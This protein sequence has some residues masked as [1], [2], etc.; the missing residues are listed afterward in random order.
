MI[1]LTQILLSSSFS[2]YLGCRARLQ[3][4][5]QISSVSMVYGS[6]ISQVSVL[7][8]CNKKPSESQFL[9]T[10]NI[11]SQVHGFVF[12]RFM[13][14]SFSVIQ[15]VLAEFGWDRLYFRLCVRLTLALCVFILRLWKDCCLSGVCSCDKGLKLTG[16]VEF[17]TAF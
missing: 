16:L 10:V 5:E 15:L 6:C 11:Y 7:K 17:C 9:R 2:A 8:L 4:R 14:L 12:H 13:G 3:K 1:L